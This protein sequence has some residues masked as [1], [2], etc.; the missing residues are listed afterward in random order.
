[1]RRLLGLPDNRPIL[2]SVGSLT[3][4]KGFHILIDAIA[5]LRL[6]RPDVLLVIVGE[7]DYRSK[8]EKQILGGGLSQNV[9]LVG[10]QAHENLS[11]WYSA[12]DVFSL[13]SG[14]EGCPNV[15]MEAMACGRPIVT[16]RAAAAII[17]SSRFGIL[18]DRTP[19]EFQHTLDQALARKWDHEAIVD[20]ARCNGWDTV[21]QRVL[22]VF[23]DTVAQRNRN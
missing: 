12:A 21:A 6:R 2:L 11:A 3:E 9:R 13:A 20:H 16:T 4:N 5:R 8:L 23:L 10:A 7:G 18:V 14:R 17:P 22:R 15:V 19:D 1:M